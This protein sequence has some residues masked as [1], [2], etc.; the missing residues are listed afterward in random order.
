MIILTIIAV[1]LVLALFYMLLIAPRCVRRADMSRMRGWIYAHRGMFTNPDI[2]ENSMPAFAL[3][4]EHGYGIELD[5]HLTRDGKI[6]VYHDDQLER[7]CGADGRIE[8]LTYDEVTRLRLFGTDEHPPLFTDFLALVNGQVPLIIELKGRS[9]DT[10]L[11]DATYEILKGYSGD[12]CIES[13]NPMLI[14]R[15]RK[16]APKTATGLLMTDYSKDKDN[17][18]FLLFNSFIQNA[19]ARPDFIAYDKTCDKNF[20]FRLICAVFNPYTAAWTIRT[21]EDFVRC[22]REYDMPICENLAE[23]HEAY[24]N[25]EKQN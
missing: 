25:A 15:F 18:K 21:R 4:V 12:Y 22:R 14:R 17:R 13:F 20:V 23:I 19:L 7:V 9:R 16:I 6:V 24:S 8:D 11:A 10:S 2:P 5:L 1:I 3:A